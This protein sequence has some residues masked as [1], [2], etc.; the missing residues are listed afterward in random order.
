[1]D[2]VRERRPDYGADPALRQRLIKRIALAGLAV[3]VLLG[4]LAIIDRYYVPPPAKPPRALSASLTPPPAPPAESPV[5][6]EAA[7]APA[8]TVPEESAAPPIDRPAVPERKEHGEKPAAG[9][10]HSAHHPAPRTASRPS[11]PAKPLASNGKP[12]RQF[13]VQMGVFSDVDNARALNEK[14]KEAGVPSRIEAK[15]QVGPF[16]S[17]AEADAARRKLAELGLQPG[18]L[19]PVRK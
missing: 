4:G 9:S 8:A 5:A 18:N 6:A 19:M 11:V 10:P 12:Q 13:V 1:M 17:R 7:S 3:V 2:D 15:V 14:L 16:K